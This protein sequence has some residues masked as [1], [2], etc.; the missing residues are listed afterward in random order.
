MKPVNCANAIEATEPHMIPIPTTVATT[1]FG[2]MSETI[3]NK[4]AAQPWWDAA[5]RPM[6][7]VASQRWEAC[8][9][10]ITGATQ[11]AQ[12]SRAVLDRK[13][14]RPELQSLRHL[15]CRLL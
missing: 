14:T 13:S 8:A 1:R 9:A 11:R 12:M 7:K 6:T 3:V 2:N 10:K 15:V 4:L 5:A